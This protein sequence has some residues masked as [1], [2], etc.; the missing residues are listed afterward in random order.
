[1]HLLM[2]ILSAQLLRTISR[3]IATT[4]SCFV[5]HLLILSGAATLSGVRANRAGFCCVQEWSCGRM[6]ATSMAH[7]I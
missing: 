6:L 5:V 2:M 1:M 3:W 4:W 7:G